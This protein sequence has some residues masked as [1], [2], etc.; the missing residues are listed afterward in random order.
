MSA[1][2][3]SSHGRRVGRRPRLRRLGRAAAGEA[4]LA[5]AAAHPARIVVAPRL[6]VRV[7]LETGAHVAATAETAAD[8]AGVHV[9]PPGAVH[10]GGEA[11]ADGAIA[12]LVHGADGLVAPVGAGA[13][14]DPVEERARDGEAEVGGRGRRRAE[15]GV[16]GGLG[17]LLESR[18]NAD[19]EGVPHKVYRTL[20]S[21]HATET[22]AG[23]ISTLIWAETFVAQRAL[24]VS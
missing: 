1:L 7:G 20:A 17:L 18:R 9:A 15:E 16:D 6:A 11:D 14:R 24:M 5:E 4:A 22:R 23:E 3:P 2:F 13:A 12:A 19:R 10:P 8:V 21:W